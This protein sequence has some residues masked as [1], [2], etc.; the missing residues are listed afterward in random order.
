MTAA[1]KARKKVARAAKKTGAKRGAARRV[2]Q[3]AAPADAA[4]LPEPTVPDGGGDGVPS[5]RRPP[6][7]TW[8]G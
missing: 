2:G 4:P 8:G 7:K 1:T 5:A 6:P 3:S